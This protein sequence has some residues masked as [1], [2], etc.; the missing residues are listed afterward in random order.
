MPILD[1][2]RAARGVLERV[3][4]QERQPSQLARMPEATPLEGTNMSLWWSQIPDFWAEAFGTSSAFISPAMAEK[5]WVAERC[6]QLNA[7]QIAAMP[8]HFHSTAE[9]GGYEP[10]WISSPDP[11]WYPN[12]ISDVIFAIVKQLY[13]WGFSCQL[14]TSRYASGFPQTFTVLDSSVMSIDVKNGRRTY[15]AGELELDPMD[16]VQID[17]NPSNALHGSSAIRAFA[18]QAWGLLAGSELSRSVMQGGIPSTVLKSERKLTKEQAEAIQAQWTARL[19]ERGGAPPVLPPELSFE[20]ISMSPDDLLLIDG[21]EFDARILASAYGVP[22]FL[23]NLVLAGGL[24]YQNP[25]MLGEYW[26][27]FEL[28]TTAKR[29]TDAF[30][31]QMLPRGNWVDFDAADTFAPLMPESGEDDV[32]LSLPLEP[33]N[34][35]GASPVDQNG[36]GAVR[37][38]RPLEVRV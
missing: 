33:P 25:A 37:P 27:R 24:T 26:W 14:V 35:A 18:T 4:K 22:A 19:S 34:V 17:R 6:M 13:G 11:N 15:K 21:L 16:V 32:Q 2:F 38:I 31:A 8:L 3:Y 10:A 23:L 30:T 29:I 9:G 7:Q 36:N 1:D 20:K 5:V 28:R 12:G